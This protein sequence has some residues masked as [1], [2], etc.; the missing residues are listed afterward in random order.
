MKK[1]STDDIWQK[2]SSNEIGFFS[3]YN[4]TNVPSGPGVYSWFLP[5]SL[6][7]RE[8]RQL[9]DVLLQTRT[10]QSYDS[11]IKGQAE[12]SQNYSFSWDPMNVTLSKDL[13]PQNISI[14]DSDEVIWEEISE[15]DNYI[16]DVTKLYALAGTIFTR[17]LYIGKTSNLARRYEE[18]VK[19]YNKGGDKNTFYSR[20]TKYMESLNLNLRIKDL[21][22]VSINFS[23]ILEFS[24]KN[25]LNKQLTLIETILKVL[26]QP[27]FGEK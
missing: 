6:K 14:S 26:S 10:I 12:L 22:F 24:D 23:E 19:G 2:L 25:L 27:I 18:H 21:I 11:I 9:R 5:V 16:H 8:N 15:S 4:S 1:I 3:Q 20:F 13:D 17:P 7:L